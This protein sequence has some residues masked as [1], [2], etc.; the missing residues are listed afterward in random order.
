MSGSLLVL[1]TGMRSGHFTQETVVALQ[2]ADAVAHCIGDPVSRQVIESIRTQAA[3][4]PPED[5]ARFYGEGKPR[6]ESYAQMVGRILE[7][8]RSGLNVAAAFYGHA[9]VFAYPSHESVRQAR[10]EGYPAE[11]WPGVSAL[12]CLFADLGV[13][14]AYGCQELEATDFLLKQR[15]LDTSG[16]VILWQIGVVGHIDYHR[17]GYDL[18]PVQLVVEK[19]LRLYPPNH[20]VTLYQA[21]HLIMA[22]STQQEVPLSELPQASISP[23]ATLFIPPLSQAPVDH[24]MLEKLN[25]SMNT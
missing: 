9:G 14:P 15:P 19:L 7:L 6:R 4:S 21:A 20:P 3:K 16:C 24:E 17:E 18:K 8:V 25:L 13:D 11:M 12:D 2:K 23:I 10:K 5:L 1:S 22:S